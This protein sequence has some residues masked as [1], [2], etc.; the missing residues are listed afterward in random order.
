MAK[1]KKSRTINK[2]EKIRRQ[3]DNGD[4]LIYQQQ[5]KTRISGIVC[6]VFGN[7]QW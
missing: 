2:N 3:N 5:K 1:I 6:V 7:G 4:E